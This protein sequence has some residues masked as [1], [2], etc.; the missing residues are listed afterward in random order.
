MNLDI[1]CVLVRWSRY[2][3]LE[4]IIVINVHAVLSGWGEHIQVGLN[5][6]HNH[7]EWSLRAFLLSGITSC[8]RFMLYIYSRLRIKCFQGALAIY[9]TVG[10]TWD[11]SLVFEP[12]PMGR[13]APTAHHQ[14]ILML[15][16]EFRAADFLLHH[17][18]LYLYTVF[19]CTENLSF[20]WHRE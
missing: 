15:W 4:V 5:P 16:F 14:F 7:K 6:F 20:Q 8:F 10:C 19:F 17:F 13:G 3:D 12:F 18:W 2:Y 11:G 9:C 1:C